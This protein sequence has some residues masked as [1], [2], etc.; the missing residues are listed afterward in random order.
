[1]ATHGK[2]SHKERQNFVASPLSQLERYAEQTLR[3]RESHVHEIDAQLNELLW[4]HWKAYRALQRD[5]K[6][7]VTTES[8]T[9]PRDANG[10]PTGPPVL[11]VTE[12]KTT[13]CERVPG[14]EHLTAI[15]N[16]LRSKRELYGVDA[17]KKI[18]V[19]KLTITLQQLTVQRGFLE[20]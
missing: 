6:R 10:D 1:V 11:E 4:E 14:A 13:V 16:I 12:I 7:V 2:K 18:D 9:T 20:N 19:K 15:H 3:T 5:A 17:P 8:V